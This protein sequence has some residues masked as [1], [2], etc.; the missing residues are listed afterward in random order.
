MA[1]KESNATCVKDYMGNK[2]V[3]IDSDTITLEIANKMMK[4]QVSAVI[5]VDSGKPVAILRARS[6]PAGIRKG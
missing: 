3:T 5:V 4:K 6:D 2:L 1:Q